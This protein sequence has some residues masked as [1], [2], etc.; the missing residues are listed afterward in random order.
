[1]NLRGSDTILKAHI[2][3]HQGAPRKPNCHHN[4]RRMAVSP[5]DLSRTTVFTWIRTPHCH[6]LFR[7][8]TNTAA[9]PRLVRGP[10]S[11]AAVDA[12][13]LS[14]IIFLHKRSSE[15]GA[16]PGSSAGWRVGPNTKVAGS[17]PGPGP[18][19]SPPMKSPNKWVFL[20]PPSSL[21]KT[22]P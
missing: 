21:S 7:P 10:S 18:G 16:W 6:S 19:K 20:S 3:L 1:M 15:P 4:L 8:P 9:I 12:R 13:R 5:Q 22:N 11:A 2:C 14:L 17:I